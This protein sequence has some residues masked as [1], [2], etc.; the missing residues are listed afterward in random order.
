MLV[1]VE[2]NLIEQLRF[3]SMSKT[4]LI[5]HQVG[6][7]KPIHDIIL[8]LLQVK[9]VELCALTQ[10]SC[11]LTQ[12]KYCWLRIPLVALRLPAPLNSI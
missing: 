2:Y 11:W 6:G 9:S 5:R 10:I 4:E 1:P 12:E 8:P 7:I 3:V